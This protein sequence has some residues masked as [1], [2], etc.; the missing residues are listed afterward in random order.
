[1]KRNYVKEKSFDLA[2][3]EI[4]FV[5]ELRSKDKMIL[6][7][8]LVRC[9]TSVGANISEA[10]HS[11]SRADFIHKMKIAAKELEETKYWL[12]LCKLSKGYP[13]RDEIKRT[14]EEVGL[15]LFKI[16]ASSK[17]KMR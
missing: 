5:E 10:Q 2:L 7:N 9:G 11:E 14:A 1:M 12:E 17:A 13:Y 8:Q 4:D 16:I 6:G 3:Q 15:I